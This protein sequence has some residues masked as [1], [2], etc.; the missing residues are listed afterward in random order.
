MKTI[1]KY[2]YILLMFSCLFSC[3][4][5]T[6][7]N[8]NPNALTDENV[9]PGYILTSVLT[10]TASKYADLSLTGN[11]TLC[12]IPAAMQYIQQDFSGY[13]LTNNFVWNALSVDYRGLYLPLSNASYLGTRA[14][15]NVDSLFIKGTSLVMQSLWFG[16]YT[17]AWGDIPYSEAFSAGENVLEPVYD[18]QIDVFAGILNTL[19]TANDCFMRISTINSSTLISGDLLYKG[20]V[21]KWRQFANSL[22]LRFLMRL[23]EKTSEMK[24]IGIDVKDAFNKIVADPA[25]YPIIT[26]SSDN[27]SMSFPGT[28]T[29][30]SWPMGALNR[31]SISE[32]Y[33]KKPG[34]PIINFLKEHNDPRL[35]CWFRPVDVQTLVRDKGSD[36]VIEKD[37]K[38]VVKRYLKTNNLGIDTSLYV[39]LGIS[40]TDPDGY[41]NNVS[42]QRSLAFALDNTFYSGGATN[43]FVSYL[44]LIFRADTNPLVK[45]IFISASE[46]NFTLAEAAY[47]GWISG[48]GLTYYLN[49]VFASLDQYN[50]TDGDVAVYNSTTHQTVSYDKS[51]FQKRLTA[52]YENAADPLAVIIHQKWA[53]E[54]GTTDGWFDWRRTGYPSLGKNLIN[55]PRGEQIPVRFMYGSSE[56]NYNTANTNIAISRLDPATNEQWSKMWLIQGTGKPY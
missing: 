19:E 55:G 1:K 16:F 27:A 6:E 8:E 2:Y 12:I 9:S 7:T 10:G 25:T 51:V 43:P 35:T 44:S 14:N 33:R 41:N 47:K 39:G 38:G 36:V 5:L 37:N 18:N 17:C 29:S 48:N 21:L 26:S 22:K 53:A 34:A 13:N 20:D 46:V 31:P 30:D 54:F 56:L 32:F 15:N 4:N 28:K 23:S 40:L 24:A 49:G 42:S 11:T 3:K 52:D 50:I 45:S